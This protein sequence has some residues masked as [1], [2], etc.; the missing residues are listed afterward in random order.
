MLAAA[1]QLPI[2]LWLGRWMCRREF[3]GR[4]LVQS[5]LVLPMFLP[6]VAVGL[7]LLLMLGPGGPMGGVF[8]G[9][10]YTE[11]A[12]VLAA[13]TVSFPLVLRHCQEAFEAVPERLS[14]VSMS[15][16]LSR[17]QTFVR[18]ELPL[19]RSGVAVGV[20]LSFARGIS[21]YGATAVVAGVTPGQTETLATGLMRRL[22][23]GDDGGALMLAWVS[24]ALGF[25]AVMISET[26]L[27]RRP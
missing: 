4:S 9:V 20:L 16:G 6:P 27:R 12:A 5:V 7:I 14:Q 24:I 17:W 13:A 3:F 19:A 18:V 15:L 2:A 26:W 21:E 10:L 25:A 22:N 11:T 1:L 8:G 23:T